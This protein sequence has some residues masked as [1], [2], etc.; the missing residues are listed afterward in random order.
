MP[1]LAETLTTAVPPLHKI[2]EEEAVATI[3][4]TLI[5]IL[6]VEVHPFKSVPLIEY[7]EFTVGV[8]VILLFVELFDQV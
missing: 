4:V 3:F 2:E 5:V 1:P 6:E 7:T 8:S